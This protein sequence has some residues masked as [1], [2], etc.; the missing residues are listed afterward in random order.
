[1]CGTEMSYV[2]GFNDLSTATNTC[3]A[4]VNPKGPEACLRCAPN[5][6]AWCQ[7]GADFRFVCRFVSFAFFVAPFGGKK[8]LL[9]EQCR[10]MFELFHKRQGD[11]LDE[12]SHYSLGSHD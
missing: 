12:A 11:M 7:T 10:Y 9:W 4:V 2:K 1:M 3:V 5:V 6:R 8:V